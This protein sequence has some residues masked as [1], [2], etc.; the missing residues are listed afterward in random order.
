MPEAIPLDET[1]ESVSES[2]AGKRDDTVVAH[3][4]GSLDECLGK[5]MGGV[6]VQSFNDVFRNIANVFVQQG[7][8]AYAGS[9]GQ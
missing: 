3:A 2:H 7:K 9:D 6:Q 8:E 5:T 1:N 4:I